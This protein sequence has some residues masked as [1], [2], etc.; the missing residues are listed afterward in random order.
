MEPL[1]LRARGE[2]GA[3]YYFVRP[4]GRISAKAYLDQLQ[5]NIRNK[6]K[7]S[8]SMFI[9]KGP[10][11][12]KLERFKSLHSDGKPL[13]EFK[14]H[15]SSPRIYAVRE[16]FSLGEGT[17]KVQIAVA[18]LLDG[19]TKEKQGKGK[20]EPIKIGAAKSLY[21][22]YLQLGGREHNGKLESMGTVAERAYR[23]RR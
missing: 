17:A 10:A 3:I 2:R 7:G 5:E 21:Y 9:E 15:G 4:N 14:E 1:Q 8:F 20:E 13:W 11:Y 18:V 23:S 16:V 6:F 12:E 19:W 22:E